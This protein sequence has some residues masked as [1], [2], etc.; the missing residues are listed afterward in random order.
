MG[1]NSFLPDYFLREV[2]HVAVRTSLSET[3]RKFCSF[4]M[5]S[6]PWIRNLFRLRTIFDRKN[7][8]PFHL[9]LR[10]AYQK[11]GFIL[12]EEI[13]G[14]ELVVGA[15]GKFWRPAIAFKKVNA[16]EYA[17]FHREGFAKVAW[18]LRCEPRI[19]GGTL[20]S[21]ELRVGANDAISAVK[22]RTYYS[23]IGPFSRRIRRTIN[24]FFEKELDSVFAGELT[25][26][27]PG[28]SIIENPSGTM[29]DGITIEAPPEAIWP[30]LMQMGC[31]R[32]G[33]Y[34]YD[35]LDNAG[36]QSS[37]QIIEDWQDLKEGDSLNWTPQADAGC[38]VM[39][40][41]PF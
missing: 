4:D 34:S 17:D 14:K 40:V 30:W 2:H 31:L 15:I 9:T 38:F 20:C 26:T 22:M 28:D 10:D 16:C 24:R 3:F 39:R 8:E 41:E 29:T 19:G 25:R 7:E 32:G 36:V 12:L 11:G 5:S 13:P 37:K 27:L 33:W 21:F 18:S 35:W 23:F 6:I 1:L